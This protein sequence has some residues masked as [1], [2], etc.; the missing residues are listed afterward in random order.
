MK[1]G[2]CAVNIRFGRDTARPSTLVEQY[3]ELVLMRTSIN[4][5]VH[6]GTPVEPSS[7]DDCRLHHTRCQDPFTIE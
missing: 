4:I 5:V 2:V 6:Y 7:V 1:R 3:H